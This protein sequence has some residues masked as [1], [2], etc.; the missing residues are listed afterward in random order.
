MKRIEPLVSIILPIYNSKEYLRKCLESV[1]GQTYKNLEIICIDDGSTDGSEVILDEFGKKD[2]RIKIVHKEN[3]GESSARN[4]GLKIMSGSYVGF[5]DCDDWIE[6]Q[7]YEK[8]VHAML[9]QDVDI[10]AASWYKDIDTV[11][12]KIENSGQ[13]KKEAFGRNELLN[14]IYQRDS[15][16]GFAYM[17]NKL[18][19]RELFYDRKG[20]LILFPEDLA[21]GGDVLYLARLAFNS[22][23]AFYIDEGFYHYYQ[24]ST[25]GCHT[26]D[27]KKRMDWIEAYRRVIE[28]AVKN[29]TDEAVLIWIKRFMAYHSSNVA[30]LAYVQ[31]N[32]KILDQCINIMKCY[33]KEYV[34]TNGQYSERIQRYNQ[35]LE[36]RLE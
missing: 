3:N 27:L 1:C 24:R 22:K 30:E 2:E 29:G 32:K 34:S 10:V 5:V 16:R 9:E 21:L 26:T 13:V 7:M 15:Y 23:R 6:A 28:Y 8:L 35:I 12:Q 4:A 31:K 14:Y 18:Y 33:Y 20:E 19:R 25:S 36:Y 11:S 17:W